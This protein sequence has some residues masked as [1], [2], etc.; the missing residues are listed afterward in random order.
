LGSGLQETQPQHQA[1]DSKFI[2]MSASMLIF[3]NPCCSV[4]NKLC[5]EHFR[6]I[7]YLGLS[8]WIF[9]GLE[10]KIDYLGTLLVAKNGFNTPNQCLRLVWIFLR[11]PSFVLCMIICCITCIVSFWLKK[12]VSLYWFLCSSL[13]EKWAFLSVIYLG[14]VALELK[15]DKHKHH[16]DNQQ[17]QHNYM[18]NKTTNQ[19]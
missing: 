12:I 2:S 7:T 5:N 9:H 13:V 4:A 18:S 15:N 16:H 10:W 14:L 1:H 19:G 6:P 3:V 8:D 11:K 17:I